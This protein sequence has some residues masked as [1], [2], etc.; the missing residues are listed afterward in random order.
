MAV[1]MPLTSKFA[2]LHCREAIELANSTDFSSAEER[3]SGRGR[4][5]TRFRQ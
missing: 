4:F 2:L 5:W 1:E 3:L